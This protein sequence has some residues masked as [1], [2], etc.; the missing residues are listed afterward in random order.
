MAYKTKKKL[1]DRIIEF[2]DKPA[3]STRAMRGGWAGTRT[4]QALIVIKIYTLPQRIQ[5]PEYTEKKLFGNKCSFFVV[6][7][8]KVFLRS[9]FVFFLFENTHS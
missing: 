2:R 6:V 7:F 4:R 9:L 1:F 3:R 5:K 8:H